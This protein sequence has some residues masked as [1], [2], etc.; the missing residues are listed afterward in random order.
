MKKDKYGI[1]QIT[2][3]ESS[4]FNTILESKEFH[5]TL[6]ILFKKEYVLST[7]KVK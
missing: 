5:C 1:K 6:T 3:S 7:L 2:Q 4:Y